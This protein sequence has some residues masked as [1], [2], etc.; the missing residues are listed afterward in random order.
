MEKRA[1]IAVVISILIIILYQEYMRR[2]YPPAPPPKETAAK[3]ETQPA[4]PPVTAVKPAAPSPAPAPE[5]VKPAA[6]VPV[7]DV[8]VETPDYIA[9]FTNQGA[10]LKSFRLKRYRA[11]VAADSPLIEMATP[12]P[13]M[14]YP[15]GLRLDDTPGGTDR[16]IVYEIQGT[17]L[18]LNPGGDGQIT[19]VG[20]TPSGRRVVKEFTFNGSSYA[21][22]VAVSIGGSAQ[23]VVLLLTTGGEAKGVKGDGIFEGLIALREGEI[24]REWPGDIEARIN[25]N[26]PLSWAGF[27]YTYFVSALIPAD[28]VEA[29]AAVVPAAGRDQGLVLETRGRVLSS[30]ERSARYRLFMGPKG[31]QPARVL[32]PRSR[33]V[34]RLRLLRV[35]L[36]AD[37]PGAA[38]LSDLHRE[39]RPRHHPADAHHQAAAVAVDAQE[40]RLHEAHAETAAADAAPQGQVRR[41]QAA[42][43]QGDDGPLQ[44][45]TR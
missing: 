38:L 42:A 21:V 44:S 10:R 16:G 22:E 31:A 13:G 23:G 6:A 19:F 17:D 20:A 12:G 29:D 43:E 41:R 27:G 24:A 1:F 26:A 34:H 39:L 15:L 3:P 2:F 32:R 33:G 25:L 28:G 4:A 7:R 30:T 37:A 18:N 14:E 8:T 40:L 36:D 11:S 9:R 45:G 35:H 5:A